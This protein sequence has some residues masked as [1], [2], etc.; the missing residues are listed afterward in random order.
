MKTNFQLFD[1]F[2][3]RHSSFEEIAQSFVSNDDFF[4]IAKNNHSFI[5]GP[6]GCGKTTMFKMLTVSAQHFWNPT[7]KNEQLLKES[8]PY[9]AIYIPSDELWKDQL[10]K[11]TKPISKDE[12]LVNFVSNALITLNILTNFCSNIKN[13]IEIKKDYYS[14]D[15][16]YKFCLK[17]IRSWNLEDCVA[18]L[19]DINLAINLRKD[20]LLNKL[21]SHVLNM[22]YGTVKE[23]SFE[24]FYHTDFLD[25][26][27]NGMLAFEDV[28]FNG[29]QNKWALCFDELE[30][31]S[32]SFINILVSKLRITPA[33]IVFKLSSGPLTE[34]ENNTA[35]LFHDYE[36]IKMWPFSYNQENRYISF[37]EEIANKR[38]K[39][40]ALKNGI[41]LESLDFK[42]LF[43]DLD[44]KNTLKSEF[45][46][47]I[48]DVPEDQEGSLTWFAFKELSKLDHSF[49]NILINRGIDP[50]NPV[51]TSVEMSSTFYRKVK[52]IVIN[53]LIFN[54]YKS[55][56]YIGQ[57]SR[58]EYLIYYGKETIFRICEGNPRFIINII[59]EL[60][61]EVDDLKDINF[62]PDLQAKVIKAVSSR[63]NAM[64]NTYPT[65]GIYNGQTVDLKWLIQ[66]VGFCFENEMNTGVF[67]MHPATSFF[68]K[69]GT[70]KPMILN[71][72]HIGVGLGAFIKLDKTSDDIA[73]DDKTRFRISYL[74]SPEF[75]LPLRIYSSIKLNNILLPNPV[76]NNPNLFDE[77]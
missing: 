34:F 75:K 17:L 56:K 7:I 13:Y 66:K 64:L 73:T 20:S 69:S 76:N 51:S 27:K 54:K 52:E 16:E 6:R 1:S 67:K 44:Y 5:I 21:K 40:H 10:Q 53:R 42:S 62:P 63:F 41:D 25:A 57:R 4:E 72:I 49:R 61:S 38:I 23:L 50:Q 39:T 37:C 11:I 47:A 18:S 33:N 26:I 36:V 77:D 3:A 48:K 68:I 60:L 14:N 22:K 43:G 9:I 31:V 45:G 28:Y 59:N 19:S 8:L 35:Q 12:D 46:F 29:K 74:L 2:N 30:L 71:L 15:D 55:G 65:S 58:K 24:E 70:V 32:V